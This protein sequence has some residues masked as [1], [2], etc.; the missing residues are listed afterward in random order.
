MK[1]S[2]SYI[3]PEYGDRIIS[4]NNIKIQDTAHF[5]QVIKDADTRITFELIDRRTGKTMT[6]MTDLDPP[7]SFTRLGI[8]VVNHTRGGVMVTRV[9]TGSLGTR[10]RKLKNDD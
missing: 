6:L 4:V 9:R 7:G 2:S 5:S 10:C 8:T 3:R 1:S